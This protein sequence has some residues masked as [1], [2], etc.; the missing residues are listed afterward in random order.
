MLSN[1]STRHKRPLP[2]KPRAFLFARMYRAPSVVRMR[3]VTAAVVTDLFAR[4]ME[5]P[6][7]MPSDW[8]HATREDLPHRARVVGDY[9][10]GMTDRYALNVH[11][12]LTGRDVVLAHGV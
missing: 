4:L 11:K 10:A 2:W 5:N 9:I 3:E 6:A 7:L 1:V 8:E 12:E